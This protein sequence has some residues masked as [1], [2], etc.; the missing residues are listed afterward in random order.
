MQIEVVRKHPRAPAHAVAITWW[1][2]QGDE[3]RA[4]T[5]ERNRPKG[6]PMARLK[7][8]VEP[9]AANRVALV[10][11]EVAKRL[12]KMQAEERAKPVAAE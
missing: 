2:K 6:R 10:N 7:G 4:A 3:F 1:R 12:E 11:D 8:H 9:L 5:Q